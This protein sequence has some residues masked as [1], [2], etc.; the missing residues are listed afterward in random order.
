M[1]TRSRKPVLAFA[2]LDGEQM[3][4][5]AADAAGLLKLLANEARLQILCS[6]TGGE[7]SVGE[8]NEKIALSQSALS[9]HLKRLRD[10][11]LVTT[12]RSAQTIYYSLCESR[13]LRLIETIHEIYCG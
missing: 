7:Q 2:A 4:R 13:A 10:D 9:Q 3:Q 8:L 6:L 1:A 5:S 12:R 11:G